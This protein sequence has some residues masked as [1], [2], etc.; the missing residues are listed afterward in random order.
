MKC[1]AVGFERCFPDQF[2]HD[3]MLELP[4]NETEA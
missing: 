1:N 2:F 4:R 3:A